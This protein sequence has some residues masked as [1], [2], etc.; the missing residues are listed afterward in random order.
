[1]RRLQTVRDISYGYDIF[2]C[3]KRKGGNLPRQIQ[4]IKTERGRNI[5]FANQ[6]KPLPL[7]E[8]VGEGSQHLHEGVRAQAKPRAKYI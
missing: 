5:V 2:R 8:G 7:A 6:H 1:M 4:I 3:A